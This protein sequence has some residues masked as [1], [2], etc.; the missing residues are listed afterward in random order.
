M[1]P[2]TT[3]R[4][5]SAGA[6]AWP[7]SGLQASGVRRASAI[8]ASSAHPLGRGR[9]EVGSRPLRGVRE[10]HRPRRC[11]APP[12]TASVV[13]RVDRHARAGLG[14]DPRGLV[15]SRRRPRIGRPDGEV[16]EQLARGLAGVARGDEQEDV[17]RR[18]GDGRPR[19]VASWPRCSTVSAE[20]G[21]GDQPRV[22][23]V[24][25]A[26]ERQA[27]PA[28]AGSLVA[29]AAQRA[30]T[31]DAGRGP[32][33]RSACRC[34]P[35]PRGRRS[36]RVGLRGAPGRGPGP[37]RSARAPRRA[38]GAPAGPSAIGRGG[39][40]HRIRARERAPLERAVQRALRPGGEV[41]AGSA[42]TSS[43]RAGR[44][45]RRGRSRRRSARPMRCVDS[46]GELVIT[47]SAGRSRSAR[48]R[49]RQRHRRPAQRGRRPAPGPG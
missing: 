12:A 21:L 29:G 45:S 2:P 44:R 37:R 23:F 41:R 3:V 11:A 10:A 15:A 25:A 8:S 24:E 27:Q 6:L 5:H 35:A 39:G 18:A 47:Q 20:P 34:A 28:E 9:V 40:H 13:G 4:S 46:F 36:G 1:P 31:A 17:A 42:R 19:R 7:V 22:L 26:R 14:H 33:R 43:R 16:L 38:R 32:S 30:R 49:G 48:Q